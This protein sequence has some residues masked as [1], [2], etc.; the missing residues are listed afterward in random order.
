MILLVIPLMILFSTSAKAQNNFLVATNT[1][2]WEK[3]IITSSTT[4]MNY[5]MIFE[6]DPAP[7]QKFNKRQMI[8]RVI[9]NGEILKT[10]GLSINQT[11]LDPILPGAKQFSPS[12]KWSAGF[13]MQ[14]YINIQWK[15]K[16]F[17]FD[18]FLSAECEPVSQIDLT[19][20]H[21]IKCS[22]AF[23]F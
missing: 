13:T 20:E 15:E 11:K 16:Q 1:V 6:Y 21:A 17:S 22:I 3:M 18:S 7:S 4:E 5:N 12:K 8:S 14:D 10:K 2:E 19:P 9:R 23:K